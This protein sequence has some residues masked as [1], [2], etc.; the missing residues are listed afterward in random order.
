MNT[1]F[2]RPLRGQDALVQARVV[3]AGKALAFG[4]IDIRGADD[5]KSVCRASTTYALLLSGAAGRPP[6]EWPLSNRTNTSQSHD[7][8][9]TSAP[10]TAKPPSPRTR[11]TPSCRAIPVVLPAGGRRC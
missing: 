1:S 5:G 3:R 4:E 7:E 2:L 8:H 9:R 10:A 6:L 11:W